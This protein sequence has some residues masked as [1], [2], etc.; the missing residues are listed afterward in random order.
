MIAIFDFVVRLLGD[1]V[2]MP[3]IFIENVVLSDPISALLVV[4]GSL[5]IAGASAVFG[6]VVAGALGIP[7]PKPGSGTSE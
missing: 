3:Q 2:L 5:F 6:Y 4:F 7:L 1:L